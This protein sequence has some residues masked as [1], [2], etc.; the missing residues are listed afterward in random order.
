MPRKPKKTGPADLTDFMGAREESRAP[1][2]LT[3]QKEKTMA[4]KKSAK[5]GQYFAAGGSATGPC[6]DTIIEANKAFRDQEYCEPELI[7][8]VKKALTGDELTAELV[9]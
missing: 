7:F 8:R 3:T 9:L 2:F 5:I 1:I 4:K 6:R